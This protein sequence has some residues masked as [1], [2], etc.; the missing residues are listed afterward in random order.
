MRKLLTAEQLIVSAERKAKLR[1]MAKTIADMPESERASLAACC[2]P[3][4][5]EGRTLSLHNAC[6]VALQYPTA[7]ILGGFRQWKMAGRGSG[8]SLSGEKSI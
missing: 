5:V 1:A 6:M 2:S 3:V 8:R 4:T 7:T